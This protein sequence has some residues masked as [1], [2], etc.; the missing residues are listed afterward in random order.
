MHPA[1]AWKLWKCWSP[2]CGLSNC[3]LIM[4]KKH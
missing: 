1:K 4:Q 2:S 3:V